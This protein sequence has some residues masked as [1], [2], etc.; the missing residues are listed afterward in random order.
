[1]AILRALLPISLSLRRVPGTPG[2]ELGS[3]SPEPMAIVHETPSSRPS[4]PMPERGPDGRFMRRT[5]DSDVHARA[6]APTPPSPAAPAP[7]TTAV[8]HAAPSTAAGPSDTHGPAA[9]PMASAAAWATAPAVHAGAPLPGGRPYESA[10]R[11][12]D[13]GPVP[14]RL[15]PQPIRIVLVEDVPEVAEHVRELLRSQGRFTLVQ[16]I[17]DG[18]RAVDE[19][20]DLEPDVVLVDA[21]LQ[22]RTSGATLATRL[23]AAG[24]PAGI[25]ALT[26]PDHPL[27]TKLAE[28]ADAVVALPL[29]TVELA[30]GILDAHA[31]AAIRD[32]SAASRIVAVFSPKGGVGTTTIAYN[33]AVSLAATRLRTLLVDGCLQFG[34]VRHLLRVDPTA[35][36]ICDLPT[37][38][39]RSHDLEDVVIHHMSGLDILLAPPR[40][41]LAELLT[42]RDLEQL[43]D[44]L[45]R[46]YQAI[47]I[48]LP[49]SLGE[50][51][52]AFLDA[53]DLVLSVLTPDPATVA[54]TR[55]M[56][57]TFA[58]I[59]YPAAKVRHVLNQHDAPGAPPPDVMARALGRMPDHTV[60][61]DRSL[62]PASNARGTPFV[63]A[64]SEARV[65]ADLRRMA[66]AVRALAVTP[67]AATATWPPRQH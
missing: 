16:V 58:E 30:R 9:P 28:L 13:Q 1:M 65:S 40:P 3:S 36:S 32:P 34:G 20:R 59:G 14:E 22:G 43:I 55:T 11:P 56:A 39:V 29:R 37:H 35:P 38:S 18:G 48:D 47:V 25:V 52:L 31:A 63:V 19:I 42:G 15:G 51:T 49:S 46:T 33:L 6:T 23:R 5:A 27:E 66:E 67:A 41:E 50:P 12:G 61:S 26:V 64:Q 8:G 24:N 10:L 2:V 17:S 62:V 21:L 44:V 60:A 7:A 54:V 57:A 4:R 45:R 53:S